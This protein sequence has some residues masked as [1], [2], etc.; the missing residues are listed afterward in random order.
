V[1][2]TAEYLIRHLAQAGFVLMRQEPG[3]APTTANMPSSIG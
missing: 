3:A 2:I 1:R